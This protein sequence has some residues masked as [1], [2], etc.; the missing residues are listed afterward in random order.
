MLKARTRWQLASYD[1]AI[2]S[3]LAQAC[4]ISPLLARLLAIRGLDTPER[5]KAFLHVSEE[6]FHSPYLLDGMEKSVL[7]IREAIE[8]GEAI[9]IYGDYDAD[10][11][12]S[13]SLMVHLM[14]ELGANFDYYIPNRFKEGYGL[15]KEAL[16]HLAQ[17]GV[18]LVITV[19]TG[20]SAVEQVEHGRQLGLDIIVTDHH[21]PPAVI[22]DAYAV[23]NPKKPGC[24]YP[25]DMLAGVGVAFKL[26]HALLEKPPMHLIDLAAIGTI[27]DLVPLVDENRIFAAL[28]LRR[29]NATRNIGLKSLIRV[30]GL[31]ETELSA[32]HVGFA[33]GPRINASGRLETAE[34]AVKLLTA[35]DAA[36]ADRYA[37]ELDQLNQERQELVA[38]MAEEAIAMVEREFPIETNPVLVVAQEGWNVG[39]VGI[40]ASRLV[41]T[42]YRPTIVLGIDREKGIAKG[43]ARSIVGFD[44]YEALTACKDLLPHYGG[45]VMAAGM[46]LPIENVELLRERLRQVAH[47]CLTPEDYVPITK[48]DLATTIDE[49]G[50]DLAEQLEALAPFGMGNTTPLLLID[51]VAATDIRKIGRDEN[52]LKCTL[53]NGAK[54]LDAIGF[55]LAHLSDQF[56]PKAKLAVVGEL[57]VNEWNGKRKPQ[58]IIRD[59]SI[60]HLQVFDWRGSREKR[61]KWRQVAR[62][63]HALTVVFHEQSIAALAEAE[64][65]QP[66]F[67]HWSGQANEVISADCRWLI[68]Y[69]MP[70][71]RSALSTLLAASKQIE[72]IYCM[73]GDPEH[74]LDQIQFPRQDQFKQLYQFMRQY[75]AI[76]KIHL[77]ALAKKQ[78]LKPDILKRM[79]AVFLELSF[80]A[81]TETDYVLNPQ[82]AKSALDR[83]AY[84]QAWQEE[85][86]M[87]TELL[88]SSHEALIH[89]L[90]TWMASTPS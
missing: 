43:S 2:T 30:C 50:L 67:V 37:L 15:N 51:E 73:F 57:S 26:A 19:D 70:T 63:K 49:I 32:G 65:G 7:R 25:F 5:A 47:E 3:E 81:E 10:G 66:G 76:K 45:H 72:R 12:S 28:G 38:Q 75:P 20:I 87:A 8:R 60:P 40:V 41:E 11:V 68:L 31:E 36:Q 59:A 56:T 79:L 58:V 53:A 24:T 17:A 29:L 82:P 54:N 69:D 46:T 78:Q 13:T 14:R 55:K 80:I 89:Y 90:T 35:S 71:R 23:I 4:G 86:E 39:V 62:E 34:A 16:T 85:A 77:D 74:G 6:Q 9:C 33:I 48:V 1:E 44:M 88:L 22:P 52:H 84:Y 83:S 42:F 64:Q 61:T 27:A 21:E 18:K